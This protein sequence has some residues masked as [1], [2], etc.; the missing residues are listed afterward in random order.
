MAQQ[1][2][3][4]EIQ[5]LKDLGIE[6]DSQDTVNKNQLADLATPQPVETPVQPQQNNRPVK[7]DVDLSTEGLIPPEP[8]TP[9]TLEIEATETDGL[10][11]DSKKTLPVFPL[12][13]ISGLTLL[14]FGGLVL[15]KGNSS[16]S[17]SVSSV[18]KDIPSDVSITPTQ[19]PKSI[20]H[21]L[22]TSQQYFS[23][24]VSQQT[25]ATDSQS[26][27]ELLNNSILAATE[28]I[29]EFPDDY[30]GYQ[31]R[32]TI[33]QALIDSKPDLIDQSISDFA[34]AFKLNS[35]SASVTRSL[36]NLYAKKGDANKTILYLKQTV[37]LEPTKAQNFYDLAKIQQQAGLLSQAL[38][39]YDQLIT[40]VTDPIQKTQ[41]ESEKSALEKLVAQNPNSFEASP[42]ENQTLPDSTADLPSTVDSPT[43][44]AMAN[45]GLIVAAPEED[46]SI[47]VASQTDSNSLSGNT[48]LSSGQKEI[49]IANDNIS[50]TSQVYVTITKGGKNQNLQV[51]S[52]SDKSFTVGLDSS[53]SEDIEFKWW[54]IN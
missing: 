40:L 44:Q 38:E 12:L 6:V 46:K 45:G 36:A 2:T 32:G 50:S 42:Q 13:S 31:Q 18:S 27:V 24:A 51:L 19:V 26:T 29:K 8:I 52:K 9:P 22:L 5:K 34:S 30:R 11:P 48:T 25:T 23:Q 54:I 16:T 35:S 3:S 14:S 20:Q 4:E 37:S 43:I 7:G 33:Y 10:K 21:Y 39:T 53:I 28:A 49:T 1:F 17:A 15:L 41:V 47:S